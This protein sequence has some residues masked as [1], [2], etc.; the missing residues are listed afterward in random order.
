MMYGIKKLISRNTFRYGFLNFM[1]SIFPA[2]TKALRG[3]MG[4]TI[5]QNSF[6]YIRQNDVEDDGGRIDYSLIQISYSGG[7]P[8]VRHIPKFSL[9]QRCENTLRNFGPILLWSRLQPEK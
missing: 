4:A 9:F 5:G 8:C 1:C 7:W 2:K 3:K 6:C